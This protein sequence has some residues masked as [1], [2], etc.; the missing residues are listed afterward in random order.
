MRE[1]R[2]GWLDIGLTCVQVDTDG[3]RSEPLWRNLLAAVLSPQHRLAREAHVTLPDLMR[4]PRL[5]SHPELREVWDTSPEFH[6]TALESYLGHVS[7]GN[8]PML[9]EM[10]AGG[11]GVAIAPAAQLDSLKRVD[12]A[13]RSFEPPAP[14]LTT[15]ALLRADAHSQAVS[16]FLCRARAIP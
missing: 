9:L 12:L 10:V 8:L 16:R 3:L 15:Y 4:E 11:Y 1:L 7:V 6:D 2:D 5:L 14:P 13:V